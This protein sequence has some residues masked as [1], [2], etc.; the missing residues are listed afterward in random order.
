MKVLILILISFALS[1]FSSTLLAGQKTLCGADDRLPFQDKRIGRL[2]RNL[3]DNKACTATLISNRCAISAGHCASY[4]GFVEFD[5]PP[6]KQDGKF[7]HPVPTAIYAVD[8]AVDYED[9]KGDDWMVIRLYPNSI[10]GLYPGEERGFYPIDRTPFKDQQ[11]IRVAGHGKDDELLRNYTLQVSYG[12]ATQDTI[13]TIL[14]HNAD[15][16]GGNSGSAII[17]LD[18]ESI[19]GIHT[20]GGCAKGSNAGTI[21]DKIQRLNQAIAEC[22]ALDLGK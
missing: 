1:T 20:D 8:N 18:N 15:T 22:Q 6:S 3:E 13:N 7:N 21:V 2:V 11:R 16:M 17:N 12:T 19:V 5:V 4:Y 10:T 14:R 9:R